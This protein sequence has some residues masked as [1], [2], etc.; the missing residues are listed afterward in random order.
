M[1]IDN[2]LYEKMPKELQNL[3]KLIHTNPECPCYMLDKQSGVLKSGKVKE[4]Y[5]KHGISGFINN[6]KTIPLTG[7]GDKGGASRFFYCAKASKKEKGE[8]NNHPTVK[9]IK[10]M[11]YLVKLTSMPNPDQIYLDP[12]LGSGTTGVACKNLNRN[13]IGIELDDKYFQIVKERISV[14]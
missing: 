4:N 11:E 3:F 2:E 10:L 9:P 7:F 14:A 1:K 13:F 12:F 5:K 6:Q 8:G